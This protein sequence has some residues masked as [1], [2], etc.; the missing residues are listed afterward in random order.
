LA[1]YRIHF[2]PSKGA[3]SLGY[4]FVSYSHFFRKCTGNDQVCV[5]KIKEEFKDLKTLSKKYSSE[6]QFTVT[7]VK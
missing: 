7:K 4:S 5:A 6:D 1:K 3:K 2:P